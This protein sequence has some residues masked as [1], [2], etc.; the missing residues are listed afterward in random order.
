M[1]LGVRGRLPQ[2]LFGAAFKHHHQLACRPLWQAASSDPI[3][4]RCN[5]TQRIN[6]KI[7]V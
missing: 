5:F 6:L 2:T 4:K 1:E 3:L 7:L